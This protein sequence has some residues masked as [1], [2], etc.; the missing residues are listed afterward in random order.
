M[1]VL[2]LGAY[3]C[4]CTA[5]SHALPH[6]HVGGLTG[7]QTQCSM[8]RQ[9]VEAGWFTLL[10]TCWSQSMLLD[11]DAGWQMRWWRAWTWLFRT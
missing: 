11:G 6:A 5:C 3:A 7:M 4:S 1:K 10:G 9:A 2:T 8:C